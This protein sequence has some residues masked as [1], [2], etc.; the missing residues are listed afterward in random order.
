MKTSSYSPDKVKQKLADFFDKRH[1]NKVSKKTGFIVRQCK[2]I[3]AYEFVTSLIFCFYALVGVNI[4]NRSSAFSP[5]LVLLTNLGCPG[6]VKDMCKCENPIPKMHKN[7]FGTLPQSAAAV[8][9]YIDFYLQLDTVAA[10][11]RPC[12]C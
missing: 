9:V 5:P 3:P 7:K 11:L 12:W 8:I 6:Q 2:K 1:I 4:S 10:G